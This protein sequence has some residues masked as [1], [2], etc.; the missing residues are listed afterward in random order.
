MDI[1]IAE[2]DPVAR[3]RLVRT[4]EQ[5]GHTVVAAADGLEALELF[6]RQP[7]AVVLTDW[8]MPRLEGPELCRRLREATRETRYAYLVLCTTLDDQA[9]LLDGLAAGADD[10]LVKPL[11]RDLLAA[12]LR[13]AERITELHGRLHDQ[14]A[15]LTRLNQE[16]FASSRLD[17]LTGLGNRLRMAEDLASQAARAKRYGRPFCIGLCDVDAFKSYNDLAGHQAGDVVLRQVAQALAAAC[18]DSDDVYRYGGEEFL[19]LLPETELPG[20]QLALERLRAAVADL[21]VPHPRL[22][23]SRVTISAGVA[24]HEPGLSTAEL[25][26]RA[27]AALYR[28]KCAGRDRVEAATEVA[29][30]G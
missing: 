5:L 2:D 27:D 24:A 21:N 8:V 14:A 29:A 9:H 6:R 10:Y 13:V 12:R 18:R 11:D 23:D 7:A 22:P 3:A 15:E 19:V 16:L 30:S 26:A 28:A 20:G 4:V 17:P 1:L 25:V